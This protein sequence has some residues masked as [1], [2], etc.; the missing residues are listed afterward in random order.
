[1]LL[2][3]WFLA[4][5]LVTLRLYHQ[6]PHI[7]DAVSYA[8][9]ASLFAS[10]RI[11]LE[12]GRLAAQLRG[13][14]QVLS[15]GRLFSQYPPGA[16]VAYALG[17]FVGLEWLVGPLACLALLG[18]TRWTAS[19]LFGRACGLVVVCLGVLSPFVLFQAGSFLSHPIAGGLLA[20]A[21]AAF[22]AG[23]RGGTRR[24]YALSGV[25]LGASFVTREAATVLFALPLGARLLATR[26]WQPVVWLGACGLPFLVAY[27]V[28][29]AQLTGSALL[30]PRTI[31]DPSDH[32][33]FG[34]GIG[35]HTRHTLA[36]GLAN[37]DELLT[38][39][40]FDLFGWPPLFALGLLGLPFLLRRAETWD[41]L[42]AGGVLAFV[43]AYAAYFYHGI[44]LGPRY[45]F[46]AMPWLL[47]LGGRGVQVL[48]RLARSRAAAGV[49]LAVLSLNTLLFYLPSEVQRRTDFSAI[50]GQRKV[51]LD[52]VQTGVFGP[53]LVRV[54]NPALVVTDDWWLYNAALAALNCPQVPDCGVLF[55]LASTPDDVTRLRAQFPERP[56][57]HTADRS[58]RIVLLP[59]AP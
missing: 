52:F 45:Y 5:G 17:Q 57:L 22:V 34:D 31:F 42:A 46:E 21:L 49:P 26:R 59:D 3:I 39:L 55:M 24:W 8:F 50:P 16:P 9:Q 58:G 35:F 10:G 4:A 20:C 7:L 56:I 25:L 29:N 6:L 11:A 48:A 41:A 43:V 51:S 37:T 12:A 14:F 1:M 15:D 33:G 44:A 23:D 54:P 38:L 27:L 30:L 36:A 19:V 13:P 2:P 28:Y 32:F 18:A 47:L 40:Q 53:R